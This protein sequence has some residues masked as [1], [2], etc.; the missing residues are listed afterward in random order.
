MAVTPFDGPIP[1]Q[2]LT[3]E[4]GNV[5]WEKPPVYT[6]P[7]DAFEMYMERLGDEEVLD[8][9][10]DMLDIGVPISVVAG[11]MLSMGVMEGYH[12]IDVKLML[13]S[14]LSAQIKTLADVTGVD[15]KMSMA[16]YRDKDAEAEQRRKAKLAAKLA[17]RTGAITGAPDIGEQIVQEAQNTLQEEPDTITDMEQPMDAEAPQGLMTKEQM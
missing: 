9:V 4:P 6:D 14:L 8:D 12:S 3:S 5:P 1:G 16:D 7:L 15:Y 11:T 2:S 13:K 10:M 17:Q